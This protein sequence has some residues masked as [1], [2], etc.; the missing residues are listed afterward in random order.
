MMTLTRIKFPDSYDWRDMTQESQAE[1]HRMVKRFLDDFQ[2]GTNTFDAPGEALCVVLAGDVV[3]AMAGLNREP[4]SSS[5][6][7]G[8]I[9]RLFVLSLIHI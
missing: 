5:G 7:S 4:E 9:R 2:A 1:G 8:R 3:Q 6:R